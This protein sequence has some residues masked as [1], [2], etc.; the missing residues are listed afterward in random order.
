[1][2]APVPGFP[3][4]APDRGL[5][6]EEFAPAPVADPVTTREAPPLGA[7]PDP[8]TAALPDGR[9]VFDAGELTRHTAPHRPGSVLR[10]DGMILVFG[11]GLSGLAAARLARSRNLPVLLID[12]EAPARLDE[13]ISWLAR[14]GIKFH[15]GAWEASFLEGVST[16]VLS[17]GIA[18]SH[19]LA[20]A[21]A[22]RGIPVIGELEM[23]A[24]LAGPPIF[25]ITG[26][27]GKTT[28]T[29]LIAHIL[30]QNGFD[31]PS[32][33]NIGRAFCDT[34]LE[35]R[36][37]DLSTILVTEV[38]SFQLETI[39]SF[40]PAAA[41][42]LNI[43]PDHLDRH[44]SMAGYQDAKY[45]ITRNQT[46]EDAIALNA[47]DPLVRPL[48]ET[49]RASVYEF[50]RAGAVARG[51]FLEGGWLMMN[52]GTLNEPFP[53]MRVAEVPLRGSHNLE[54][55][56]AAS[57]VTFF[58]DLEAEK[59]AEAIRTFP[60]VEH[61][62]ELV[63]EHQGVRYFN[64]SKATNL[65]ALAVALESF[66]EP[67]ILVAGGLE[68]GADYA[69]LRP[70]VERHVKRV[71]LIGEATSRLAAAWGETV[72]CD[73]VATLEDAALLAAHVARA[74]DVVL[75]SP[76]CKSFDM[77][78]NF[79]HRGRVFKKTVLEG[80]MGIDVEGEGRARPR[81]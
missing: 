17:P 45:A 14:L 15:F 58:C 48:R 43:T 26:T 3:T 57:L 37:P 1:M 44:G 59:V 5:A 33:G 42:L 28:T 29:A 47:D 56:L 65:D 62:I 41:W 22:Q 46:I 35:K 73:P 52:C 70:L 68:S 79:E 71:L 38:S 18:R 63:G 32:C 64:D 81:P 49:T 53:L 16:L 6:R 20:R 12:E 74:G 21:A 69:R 77:F 31:A 11:A 39:H 2:S 9:G 40:R 80:I 76:G 10:E 72:A 66:N 19:P 67:I 7:S 75:L 23:G 34:L 78:D 51:A 54:N 24:C 8:A 30:S 25:A 36:N 50:S 4:A 13:R 55:V 27:N 61:R 60:G